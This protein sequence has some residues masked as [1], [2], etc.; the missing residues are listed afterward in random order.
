MQQWID[1]YMLI[2]INLSSIF[3]EYIY[4]ADDINVISEGDMSFGLL[5][6]KYLPVCV[7]ILLD[8]TVHTFLKYIY[9]ILLYFQ[10]LCILMVLVPLS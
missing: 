7:Y 4:I 10:Y 3:I 2:K 5:A 9:I 1:L 8:I 6:M